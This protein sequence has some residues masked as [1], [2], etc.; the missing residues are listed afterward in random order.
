MSPIRNLTARASAPTSK[1]T[2]PVTRVRGAMRPTASGFS[3][4]SSTAVVVLL[5]TRKMR[6]RSS[7]S[8]NGRLLIGPGTATRSARISMSTNMP[9]ARFAPENCLAKVGVR[10]TYNTRQFAAPTV[11]TSPARSTLPGRSEPPRMVPQP[12]ATRSAIATSANPG[13]NLTA[14]VGILVTATRGVAVRHE[15]RTEV[16][17]SVAHLHGSMRRVASQW[18]HGP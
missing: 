1:A 15:R 12:T 14:L 5:L 6:P 17:G 7:T 16:L 2:H 9:R 10:R 11:T 3:P 13:S 8:V 18:M 4:A